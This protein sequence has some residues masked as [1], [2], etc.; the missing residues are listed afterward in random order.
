MKQN[1]TVDITKKLINK[2]Q[3]LTEKMI[4]APKKQTEK[5]MEISERLQNPTP[6][7]AKKYLTVGVCSSV[8]ILAIGTVQYVITRSDFGIGTMIAGAISLTSNYIYY[9]R[10]IAS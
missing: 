6:E 7:K 5:M 2:P 4:A 8:G 9:R 3:A 10:K 1:Q